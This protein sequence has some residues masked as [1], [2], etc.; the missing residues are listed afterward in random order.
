M[1]LLRSLGAIW[2]FCTIGVAF[3]QQRSVTKVVIEMATIL[4][5]SQV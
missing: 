1:L 2:A 5:D 4:A 3:P